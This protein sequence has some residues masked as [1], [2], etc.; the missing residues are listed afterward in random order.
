MAAVADAGDQ[1]RTATQRLRVTRWGRGLCAVTAVG[2]GLAVASGL[3]HPT[4]LGYSYLTAWLFLASLS[5]GGLFW[6]M[7]QHLCEAGW[8]VPLRRAAEHLACL[9][10]VLGLLWLPLIGLGPRLYGWMQSGGAG[11]DPSLQ[12]KATLLNWPAWVG[13]SL[14]ILVCWSLLAW[15]LR[16]VSL[17]QDRTGAPACVSQLRR[18]SALGLCVLAVT[19]TLAAVLWA[20]ALEPHWG[21][22]VY[23]LY[24]LAASAWVTVAALY[25]LAVWLQRA[26]PMAQLLGPRQFRDLGVLWFAFTLVYAYV[27]F[28]QYFVIWNGN[29]PEHTFWYLRRQQGPWAGL[30]LALIVGHFGVPFLVLLRQDTKLSWPVTVPLAV[31][32]GLMH[33]LDVAFNVLPAMPPAQPRGFGLGDLG[34]L[35]FMGGVLGWAWLRA[36]QAHP[37]FPLRDPRLRDALA[38]AQP[39]T[40]VAVTTP[41]QPKS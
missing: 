38:V 36:F 7:V 29:I 10:P 4:R 28:V 12:A 14:L 8:W 20:M 26:G 6:V 35:A 15:R 22:A 17:A 1:A 5:V 23:G 11:A 40:A 31:W 34:C 33:Y 41:V 27:H 2:A 16:A 3:S 37:A 32:C 24:Y 19:V 21:S 13:L 9:A 25:G 18:V 39:G 30:G